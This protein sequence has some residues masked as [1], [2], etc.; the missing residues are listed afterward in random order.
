[1]LNQVRN[2]GCPELTAADAVQVAGAAAV[3]SL[4]GPTCPLLMGRPDSGTTDN[5]TGLP[6][7]C[8]NDTTQIVPGGLIGR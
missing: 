4:G 6:S 1:M 8:D 5:T 7:Q 3:A 2:N